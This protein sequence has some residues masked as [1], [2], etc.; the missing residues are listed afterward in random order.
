M[1]TD[2]ITRNASKHNAAVTQYAMSSGRELNLLAVQDIVMMLSSVAG[3]FLV[4]F[5][6]EVLPPRFFSDGEHIRQI[7]LGQVSGFADKSYESVAALYRLLL[8]GSNDTFAALV[9]FLAYI[10]VILL[11]RRRLRVSPTN[12]FATVLLATSIILAAAFLGYYSKDVFVLPIVALVLMSSV[13]RKMDIAIVGAM[14]LY[15]VFFRNYWLVIAVLYLAFAIL[16]KAKHRLRLVIAAV[17]TSIVLVSF[18]L[19]LLLGVPPDYFRTS[20]NIGRA[21]GVDAA[22]LIHPFVFLPGP[23]GGVANNL[24]TFAALMFPWPL[25]QLGGAYYAALALMIAA[26]WGRFWVSLRAMAKDSNYDSDATVIRCFALVLAFIVTQSLFE[27][28]YG[29]SLRHLT[30]IMPCMVYTV[31]S[32]ARPAADRSFSRAQLRRA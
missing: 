15:G 31:W 12:I 3:F 23:L 29:S 9:G 7:A 1:T 13:R 25:A 28:D 16:L 21:D 5:R 4:L 11:V 18:S 26:F 10:A 17:I 32:A 24:L 8:L 27:P 19:P 14:V 22:T 6:K 20:V 2:G 30:P